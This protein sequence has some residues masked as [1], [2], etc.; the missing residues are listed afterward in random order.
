MFNVQI[1]VGRIANV[2]KTEVYGGKKCTKFTVATTDYVNGEE[3]VEFHYITAWGKGLATLFGEKLKKG[4]A[5]AFMGRT[6]HSN[7]EKDG[8]QH[9]MT[10]VVIDENT[11]VSIVAKAKAN[12]N[13]ED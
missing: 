12:R 4:D 13:S 11:R 10:S 3:K 6:E 8:Q 7:F 5:V 1:V 9:R 2:A